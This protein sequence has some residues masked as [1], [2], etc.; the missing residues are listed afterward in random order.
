MRDIRSDLQERANVVE[1]QI[2]GVCAHYEKVVEQLQ[3]E[4]DARIAELQST[5]SM[6]TKLIEFESALAENVVPLEN[7]KIPRPSLAERIK[8]ANG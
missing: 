5:R 6:I 8:A 1:E 7:S 2:R 4:R 3:R